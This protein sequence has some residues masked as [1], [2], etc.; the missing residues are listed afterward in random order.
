MKGKKLVD[1][2]FFWL[3]PCPVWARHRQE[4]KYVKFEEGGNTYI[5]YMKKP[6]QLLG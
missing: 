6:C 4:P 2:I 1:N 3:R 5:F